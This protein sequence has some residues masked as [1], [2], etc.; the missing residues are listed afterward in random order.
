MTVS[1]DDRPDRPLSVL[2]CPAEDRVMIKAPRYSTVMPRWPLDASCVR[3]SSA[4][5]QRSVP[6]HRGMAAQRLQGPTYTGTVGFGDD[7]R[8]KT[9]DQ[10]S[11]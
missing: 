4:H 7:G 6:R 1:A 3:A 11:P 5:T 10:A 2:T 9:D 8:R